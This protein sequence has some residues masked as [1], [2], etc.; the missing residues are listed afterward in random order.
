LGEKPGTAS[1]LRSAGDFTRQ[2]RIPSYEM[3]VKF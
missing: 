3:A 2:C 1:V